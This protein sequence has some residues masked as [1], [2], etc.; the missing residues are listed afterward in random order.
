MSLKK[1]KV[2]VTVLLILI[3]F[4]SFIGF[5]VVIGLSLSSQNGICET[6]YPISNVVGYG[7]DT[8][9][10]IYIGRSFPNQIQIY[11]DNGTFLYAYTFHAFGGSY[12][13]EVIEDDVYVYTARKDKKYHFTGRNLIAVSDSNIP[14][15]SEPSNKYSIKDEDGTVYLKSFDDIV[16]IS[17]TGD[18]K[19][20][21]KGNFLVSALFF[22][23]TYLFLGLGSL[24]FLFFMHR[25][26]FS[27][28]NA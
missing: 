4:I 15:N 19:I 26:L 17:K 8:Q 16:K 2:I 9:H 28:Y 3:F 27:P 21:I 18:E 5:F 20:L 10:R 11:D 7:I 22:P 12:R 25:K 1:L 13:F 14:F 23:F 6:E 24:L